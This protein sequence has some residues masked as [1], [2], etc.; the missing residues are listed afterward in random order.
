MTGNPVEGFEAHGPFSDR[1]VAIHWVAIQMATENTEKF[2]AD[3]WIMPLQSMS[4]EAQ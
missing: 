1:W 3:W 4:E 2:E